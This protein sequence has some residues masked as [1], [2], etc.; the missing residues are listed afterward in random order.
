MRRHAVRASPA[1]PGLQ[2]HSAWWLRLVHSALRPHK[3]RPLHA[4]WHWDRPFA[5]CTHISSTSQSSSVL[6][7]NSCIQMLLKQYWKSG[8]LELLRHVGWHTPWIHN[9]SP[10]QSR[11]FVHTE[12][13]TPLLHTVPL[14]HCWS[15]LQ[16]C[17]GTHPSRGFPVVPA[18]HEHTA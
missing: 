11:L 4:F 5:S 17:T 1:N 16:Y 2:S 18:R 10:K 6:Q 9:W 7:I 14:G 15:A 12:Q 13:H 8:Q 3:F